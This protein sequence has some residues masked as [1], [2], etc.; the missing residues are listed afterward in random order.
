MGKPIT[1]HVKCPKRKT[2]TFYQITVMSKKK[3]AVYYMKRLP[4]KAIVPT[5]NYVIT[6]RMYI[7]Y[8]FLGNSF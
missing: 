7:T 1:H 2:E 8:I 6:S 4:Y 3:K 5:K